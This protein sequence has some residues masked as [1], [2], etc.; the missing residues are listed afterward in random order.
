MV[1]AATLADGT[2][3]LKPYLDYL[4]DI[5]AVE[6]VQV[7]WGKSY[8]WV[9]KIGGKKYL[10]RGGHEINNSLKKKIVSLYTSME[11]ISSSSNTK[12]IIVSV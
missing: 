12:T 4:L 1:R 10:Y 11:N 5:G 6:H 8:R 9:I 3:S 2:L 7:K